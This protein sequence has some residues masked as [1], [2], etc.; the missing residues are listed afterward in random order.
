MVFITALF[1]APVKSLIDSNVLDTLSPQDKAQYGKLRLYGQL[2]FGIGSSIVGF[3]ISHS[4]SVTIPSPA[5][6]VASVVRTQPPVPERILHE[7]MDVAIEAGASAAASEETTKG[8]LLTLSNLLSSY[9]KKHLI[10]VSSGFKVAFLVYGILS[11]PS[12]MCMKSFHHFTNTSSQASITTTTVTDADRSSKKEHDKC[13]N[14]NEPVADSSKTLIQS[15]NN[16][17]KMTTDILQGL[18]LLLHNNDALLFFFL[19][20]CVGTSSGIIENFAYVR[21]R[22][23]GGTGS[24]MGICRLVSSLSGAPMFWFSGPLTQ[25]LGADRVLVISLCSYVCRFLNYACMKN[26]YHALPA[27]SLRGITFAAFWSTSTV[28]AHRISPP[29]MSATMLMFLNAM[30]GGLG[31]SVGAIVG[32]KLQSKV[33]TVNTFLWTAVADLILAVFFGI[34]LNVRTHSNFRN[35]VP[36]HSSKNTSEDI[37]MKK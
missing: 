15:Q 7:A 19:V 25:K 24:A 37:V 10:N 12:Y 17:K 36:M 30:Y 20:F 31:Q 27:E 29:G 4:S 22:E 18:N 33:G 34:Y 11:V 5:T 32:G 28:F 1:N 23:V 14:K 3:L 21:L 8:A 26:P 35:P 13:S 2:G 16:D 6:S 9:F